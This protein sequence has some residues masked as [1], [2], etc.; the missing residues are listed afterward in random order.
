MDR[1]PDPLTWLRNGVPLTLLID[2]LSEDGPASRDIFATEVADM[3]WT[4]VR[5][6]A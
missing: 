5:H 3:T 1:L 4:N 6:A 2:L